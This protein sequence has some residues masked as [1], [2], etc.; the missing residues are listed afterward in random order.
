[1]LLKG[2]PTGMRGDALLPWV[3]GYKLLMQGLFAAFPALLVAYV[4]LALP[5][6]LVIRDHLLHEGA[7]IAAVG[8]ALFVAAMTWRCHQATGEGFTRWLAL[9]FLSF[10]LVYAPHGALTRWSDENMALFL[11]FGPASRMILAALLLLGML[12]WSRQPAPG[13]ARSGPGAWLPVVLAALALDGV[14][15]AVAHGHLMTPQTFRILGEGAAILC[16]LGAT[17]LLLLRIRVHGQLLWFFGVA[18]L[19]FC[20]SSAA[21]LLGNPW[22]H[23]WWLAHGVFAAGFCLL[24]YGVA[25]AYL[26]NGSLAAI[27]APEELIARLAARDGELMA[28][29]MLL[30]ELNHRVQNNLQLV[31]SRLTL[32]E[33][34]CP[35]AS[36]R[37]LAETA[38]GQLDVLSKIH[39]RLHQ[40]SYDGRLPLDQA[41]SDLGADLRRLAPEGVSLSVDADPLPLDVDRGVLVLLLANELVVNAF[42]HAFPSRHGHVRISLT[43]WNGHARLDVADDGV[44]LPP[45]V[46]VRDGQGLGLQLAEDLARQLGG[47]L[48]C[49]ADTSGTRFG[50]AFRVELRQPDQNS[51]I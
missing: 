34:G 42:K 46:P 16:G 25:R 23:Q 22:S 51:V 2:Y 24:S 37:R 17:L 39:R 18:V 50:M 40:T 30:R 45:A 43:R 11:L 15:W 33:L 29:E 5:D 13:P 44:G 19:W 49:E 48:D 20:T 3:R 31:S 10:A 27:Y 32:E 41:L 35:D 6:E 14:V 12:G 9:A 26:H 21:F 28:K 38:R 47:T 8:L 1:M 4:Q 36:S 7:I